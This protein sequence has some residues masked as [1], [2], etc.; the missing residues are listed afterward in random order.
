MYFNIAGFAI[1]LS[2]KGEEAFAEGLLPS[3]GAFCT[4]AAGAEQLFTMHVDDSPLPAIEP[5]ATMDF[6][7]GNGHTL[8]CPRADGSYQFA[9]SNTE[10]RPCC[11]LETNSDFTE[12]KCALSG[13][14]AMRSFGLNNALMMAFA[15]AA[16]G[17][18]AVL[19][20]ASCIVHNGLAYPFIARSG[21]G[22]STHSGLWLKHISDTELLNDD[23]PVIRIIGGKPVAYGSPWSGKTPCYSNAS[24]PI[25]AITRIS[26]AGNNS[27]ERLA[28]AQAFASLLPSCSTM[29]W[30]KAVFND[31]CDTITRIV[32]T[33]PIYTLHC[34]PNAEAALLCHDTIAR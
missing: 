33:T 25:G 7:T 11:L 15:F 5:A 2:G 24:A 18:E 27:I 6:D 14:M 1:S 22:K 26:R 28:A 20:H 34:L 12:C 16:A 31:T 10:R 9:I 32:E 21:T 30:D 29:K 4:E 17:H 8:V 23:N 13:T 19:M 3:F